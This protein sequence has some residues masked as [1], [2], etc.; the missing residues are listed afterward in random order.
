[1]N[2]PNDDDNDPFSAFEKESLL[3]TQLSSPEAID[4]NIQAINEVTKYLNE[5]RIP[6]NGDPITY[7]EGQNALKWPL[8]A[9]LAC[10]YQ[11]APA[12]SAESERMFSTAGYIVNDLRKR[13]LSKN[14]EMLLFLHHNLKIYDFKY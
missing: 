11:T 14:V 6:I 7:W 2:L 8:L 1:M 13:L 5:P 10:R 12:T 3:C 9:K 4:V